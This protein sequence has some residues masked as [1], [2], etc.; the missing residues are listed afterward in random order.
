MHASAFLSVSF[1]VFFLWKIISQNSWFKQKKMSEKE[2]TSKQ[3]GVGSCAESIHRMWLN[4]KGQCFD[5]LVLA[6]LSQK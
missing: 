1:W 3:L 6:G 4:S 2:I 5:E